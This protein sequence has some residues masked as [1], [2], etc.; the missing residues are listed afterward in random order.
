LAGTLFSS[1]TRK[2]ALGCRRSFGQ[3]IDAVLYESPGGGLLTPHFLNKSE[4]T[5]DTSITYKPIATQTLQNKNY[6]L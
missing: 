3:A 5:Q 1:R 6:G 4:P 2:R